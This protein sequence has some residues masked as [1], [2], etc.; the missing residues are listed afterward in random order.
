MLYVAYFERAA[1][2]PVRPPLRGLAFGLGFGLLVAA[3]MLGLFFGGVGKSAAFAETPAKIHRLLQDAGVSTPARYLL[4]AFFYAALHSL[5]EEY[6]WRWFVFARLCRYLPLAAAIVVSALG[7][8]AHHVVLL[9]VYFPGQFWTL[10]LPLSLGVAIGGAVWA[11]IY[12]HT[13][14][15]YAAWLSHGL[16][17]AAIFVIGYAMLLPY[18]SLA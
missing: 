15:L 16:V 7:F 1:L 12:H 8:M 2:R 14:S 6:Y 10:A 18:W 17:D 5:L 13:G 4:L 3:A 11:W 9:G